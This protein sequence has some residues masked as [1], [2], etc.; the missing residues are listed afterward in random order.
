MEQRNY[1][2]VIEFS[3]LDININ[4][5]IK[6]KLVNFGQLVRNLQIIDRI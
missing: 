1:C 4:K 5:K 3:C 6:E 2:R